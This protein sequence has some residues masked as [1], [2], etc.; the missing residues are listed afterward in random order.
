MELISYLAREKTA[1]MRKLLH[2]AISLRYL[3]DRWKLAREICENNIC[4]LYISI[5]LTYMHLRTMPE[6]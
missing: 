1:A 2:F 6:M 4:S 5:H 3:A